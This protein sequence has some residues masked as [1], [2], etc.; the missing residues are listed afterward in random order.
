MLDFYFQVCSRIP[1]HLPIKFET[2]RLRV[3]KAIQKGRDLKRKSAL[4]VVIQMSNK[5]NADGARE[6]VLKDSMVNRDA[7]T[8]GSN[9]MKSQQTR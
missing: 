8:N 2:Y 5:Q 6:F 4:V 1:S 7:S 9:G 3:L